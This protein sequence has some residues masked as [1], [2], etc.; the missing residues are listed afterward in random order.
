MING[1]VEKI[2]NKKT[3]GGR[4]GS[5]FLIPVEKFWKEGRA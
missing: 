1:F 4:V 3:T 5:R 2:N